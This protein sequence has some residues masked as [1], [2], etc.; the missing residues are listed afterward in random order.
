MSLDRAIRKAEKALEREIKIQI[1]EKAKDNSLFTINGRKIISLRKWKSLAKELG[2]YEIFRYVPTSFVHVNTVLKESLDFDVRKE[3]ERWSADYDKVL[4]SMRDPKYGAVLC[5]N[6]FFHPVYGNTPGMIKILAKGL[7]VLAPSIP[8]NVVNC[9]ECPNEKML[10]DE[11]VFDYSTYGKILFER[12][13]LA[14]R[15]S[16][17]N[18]KTFEVDFEAGTCLEYDHAVGS[19]KEGPI[20]SIV[21]RTSKIPILNS[22][23]VYACITSQKALFDLFEQYEEAISAGEM[24]QARLENEAQNIQYARKSKEEII[25]FFVKIKDSITPEDVQTLTDELI[26]QRIVQ[27]QKEILNERRKNSPIEV[28]RCEQIKKSDTC[29]DC[30]GFA[31]IRCINCNAWHCFIHLRTHAKDKHNFEFGNYKPRYQ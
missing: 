14:E 2:D 3:R 11:K 19:C 9:F 12:L 18:K 16:R 29:L 28:E 8:C 15:F 10:S 13:K 7:Q 25:G 5:Q 27:R 1:R 31:N 26:D 22:K 17:D 4:V 24:H 30:G 23:D 21:N 20:A 6:C